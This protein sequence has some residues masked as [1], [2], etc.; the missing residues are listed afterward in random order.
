MDKLF[1]DLLTKVKKVLFDTINFW[2]EIKDEQ[3]NIKQFFF[4]YVLILAAIGPVS[5]FIGYVIIGRA[6][7]F[8]IS[9]FGGLLNLI[10]S[11][12]ISIAGLFLYAFIMNQF[13]DTLS[14]K[15]DFNS[16]LKL[17]C[18]SLTPYWILSI[19]YIIPPLALISLIGGLYSLYLLYLGAQNIID[20]P[21]E[22]VFIYII[23][24]IVLVA[25]VNYTIV[26]LSSGI[27]ILK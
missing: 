12:A 10:I 7:G 15:K 14:Y 1:N 18:Y 16:H 3:L 21:K 23:V 9:I 6:F 26:L 11:Y 4:S 17:I 2:Q 19:F 13:A 22:K 27:F 25:I 5:Q 24:L 20:I 8:R